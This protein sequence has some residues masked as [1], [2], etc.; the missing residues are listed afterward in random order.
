MAA[1]PSSLKTEE[2][3]LSPGLG[4]LTLELLQLQEVMQQMAAPLV[5]AQYYHH[6]KTE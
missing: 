3:S 1:A 2:L 6:K 5:T 4:S